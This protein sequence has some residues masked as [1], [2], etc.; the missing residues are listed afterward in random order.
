MSAIKKCQ[1]RG[2]RWSGYGKVAGAAVAG[3]IGAPPSEGADIGGTAGSIYGCLTS[4]S[5]VREYRRAWRA[6]RR[7]FGGG[8]KKRKNRASP[9]PEEALAIIAESWASYKPG[10]TVYIRVANRVGWQRVR[11]GWVLPRSTIV[12]LYGPSAAS[13]SPTGILA[14]WRIMWDRSA[15]DYPA[16]DAPFRLI[17]CIARVGDFLA[18]AT[19][20]DDIEAWP[21]MRTATTAPAGAHAMAPQQA[22]ITVPITEAEAAEEPADLAGMVIAAA[23]VATTVAVA[24]KSLT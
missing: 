10:P 3:A 8:R 12:T 16:W 17:H 2:K 19:D 15:A 13:W 22:V 6:V 11:D 24:A 9:G 1:R 4:P 18:T 5:M 14:A 23:V 20:E 21:V 7:W